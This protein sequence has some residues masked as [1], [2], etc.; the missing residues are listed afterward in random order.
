M[1][2]EVVTVT[3]DDTLATA[4]KLTR[5]HRIRHLP[6]VLAS[7]TLAGILSDRDIRLAMPSPL[8]TPDAERADFLERTPVAQIMIREAITAAPDETIEDAAKLL[9]H[10]RIG[11]LPVIGPDQQLEGVLTDTDILHAFVRI[12]GVAE[13]S[14]RVEVLLADR[15]GQLGRALTLIGEVAG[16]N[17]VSVVVPSFGEGDKKT[18]ILHL[19]TIDPREALAA[20]EEAGYEVGWP[21]LRN[22]LR[23]LDE[24]EGTG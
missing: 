18:A 1:N 9:Y 4:L 14:S 19:A 20:L 7:G 24:I 23:R 10:H 15:P 3:P 5:K 21:S 22:D 16:V 8:T 2:R 6:V 12:L 17:I 13:P 11:S